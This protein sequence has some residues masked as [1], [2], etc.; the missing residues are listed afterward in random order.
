MSG[1]PISYIYAIESPF[2]PKDLANQVVIL[3]A[4]LPTEFII[5][6]HYRQ[7]ASLLYGCLESG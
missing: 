1:S 2:I 4:E 3:R 7:G 6:G 5:S